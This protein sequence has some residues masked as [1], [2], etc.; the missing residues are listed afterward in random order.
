MEG[1]GHV[2]IGTETEATHLVLNTGKTGKD[3]DRR[4]HLG[5][6]QGAKHLIAAHVRQIQIEKDDVIII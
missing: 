5:D 3:E 6:A 1:L 2:V 4:L